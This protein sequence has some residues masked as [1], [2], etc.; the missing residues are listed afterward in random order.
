M[1]HLKN[2]LGLAGYVTGGEPKNVGKNADVA[3]QKACSHV[4]G[5][6]PAARRQSIL[7]LRGRG[8]SGL[9][10]VVL[11]VPV[12][13]HV[14]WDVQYA[15][16]G[17]A[18]FLESAIGRT[19]VRTLDHRAAAA[20]DDYVGILGKACYSLL[21]RLNALGLGACAAINGMENMLAA[22]QDRERHGYNDWRVSGLDRL[23]ERI[24]LEQVRFRP[25][26]GAILAKANSGQQRKQEKGSHG[27]HHTTG[28]TVRR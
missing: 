9:G 28:S 2:R 22:I 4:A 10:W 6:E 14:S 15:N 1:P 5:R 27:F 25:G 7:F 12:R 13:V 20:I 19:D 8:G 26:I 17:E 21:E 24:R 16:M 11:A 23:G 3:G 18:H